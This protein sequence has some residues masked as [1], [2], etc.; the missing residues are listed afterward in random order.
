MSF[1]ITLP[2]PTSIPDVL[3]GKVL[4]GMFANNE[5]G[6]VYDV[7]D[8]VRYMQ[9]GVELVTNG[10][11]SE[12]T[13]GWTNTAELQSATVVSGYVRLTVSSGGAA[14]GI[15]QSLTFVIGRSYLITGRV[16]SVSGAAV[17]LAV[18]NN[19]FTTTIAS[20]PDIT[21]TVFTD[22]SLIFTATEINNRVYLRVGSAS[23]VGDFDNISVK[24]LTAL[25][26]CTLFQDSAGTT[27]VTAV[28]QPVGLML[29]K[30]KGLVLGA[31]LVT[32]GDFSSGTT[33]WFVTG[34]SGGTIT[35]TSGELALTTAGAGVLVSSPI[36]V[37]VGKTYSLS[38]AGRLGSYGPTVQFGVAATNNA[39]P[40][41]QTFTSTIQTVKTAIFTAT[42]TTMFVI[43]RFPTVGTSGQNAFFDNISVREL[44]G[45]HAFQSTAIDR[46]ILRNRYNLLTNTEQF[47][48]AAWTKAR[49]DITPNA[50]IAPDG[51]LSADLIVRNSTTLTCSTQQSI[52]AP[53]GSRV[54]FSIRAKA[55]GVGGFLGLRL[56]GAY[57]DR[58]DVLFNLSDGTFA[59]PTSTSFTS[60]V[61][62]PAINLG[63]GWWELS[64]TVTVAN[65]VLSRC[66]F[67][68]SDGSSVSVFEGSSTTLS[69]AYVWGASL[70][71][72]DQA[73]LPYQ[74]VNTATDYDSDPNKFPLYLAA[75]GTNTWMQT[76]SIDFTGTDKVTVFAGVR[77]LSDA[78]RCVVFELSPTLG[79]NAGTFL[80]TAPEVNSNPNVGLFSRGSI[81]GG[82]PVYGTSTAPASFVMNGRLGISSDENTLRLNA[83]VVGT[84]AADQGTGNFGN[85]PLYLFRRGGTSLPFNGNFYGLVIR[86]A[87]TNDDHIVDVERLLAFKTRG[88]VS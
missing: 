51:T 5:Q 14:S 59:G 2:N 8:Y 84:S 15:T 39:T 13:T 62:P 56:Q 58:A 37:V 23:G 66:L 65:S 24:E 78:S 10:N 85:Y 63:A 18:T 52:S 48:D 41:Q 9:T 7:G 46:P 34:G 33:G 75:N 26:T 22:T 69:N 20:G 73:H 35:N 81:F 43:L 71:P 54:T 32:N 3:Y 17:R 1:Q 60:V 29:D 67:S 80:F 36:S 38:G 49:T 45:N 44:P 76:N 47:D 68:P 19:S 42:A 83:A 11:F 88:F 79:S 12:G 87:L 86:G 53:I 25:D 21:S 64:I 6:V 72:A 77:K 16:R 31:E 74:R 4:S 82:T 40:S 70:V 50:I 28:E 61:V 30:S 27:P 55:A 57:P